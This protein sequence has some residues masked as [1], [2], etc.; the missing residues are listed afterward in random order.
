MLRINTATSDLLSEQI[1]YTNIVL[2]NALK[3]GIYSDTF[4]A[5]LHETKF[6]QYL[7]KIMLSNRIKFPLPRLTR[8]RV[9]QWLNIVWA[10]VLPIIGSSVFYLWIV[11]Y[12]RTISTARFNP[13]R[14]RVCGKLP[15]V[16]KIGIFRQISNL[17]TQ[18]GHVLI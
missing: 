13:L 8:I 15:I 1:L 18:Q 5:L 11:V 6:F 17:R 7:N 14:T 12:G 4:I 16:P 10:K 2:L 9:F 3:K